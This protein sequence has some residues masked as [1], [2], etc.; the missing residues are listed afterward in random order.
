MLNTQDALDVRE[1][2]ARYEMLEAE[3]TG[4]DAVTRAIVA[5]E[6]LSARRYEFEQLTAEVQA[7]LRAGRIIYW[8]GKYRLTA[9][10]HW[11]CR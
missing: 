11:S 10:G 2:I 1:I 4:D 6:N 5:G 3:T 9:M 7:H 8:H